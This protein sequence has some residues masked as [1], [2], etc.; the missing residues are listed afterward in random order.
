MSNLPKPH[1]TLWQAITAA[2]ATAL[3]ALE[4]VRELRREPGPQGDP[5]PPG[6]DA[7]KV[8]DL[9]AAYD[10]DTRKLTLTLQAGTETKSVDVV[11]TGK[12]IYR[13]VYKEGV[14]C[15]LG[16]MWTFGGSCWHCNAPTKDKPGSGSKD[17]TLA[18]KQGRD[19][20]R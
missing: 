19:F 17:W 3:K 4:E 2:L 1:Y 20:S 18:V 10:F 5:G 6:K 9:K 11:R 13:G 14:D 16:D 7:I 15:D 8:G 12:V